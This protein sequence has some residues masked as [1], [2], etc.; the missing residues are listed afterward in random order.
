[1]SVDAR[2]DQKARASEHLDRELAVIQATLD[3]A[4]EG[5]DSLRVL[6]AGCGSA[7]NLR[8][9]PGVHTTGIDISQLQLDRNRDLAERIRGDLQNYPLPEGSFDLVICWDVLEHLE[10]PG[11]ALRNMRRAL[12]PDGVMVLSLPNLMSIKGLV[13]KYTPQAFHIWFYR[14]IYRSSKTGR[15]DEGPFPTFL[16]RAISPKG[17]RRFAHENGLH[18]QH[19]GMLESRWQRLVRQRYGITGRFWKAIRIAIKCV[20]FG[21]IDPERTE[22]IVVLTGPALPS[23]AARK[24][25]QIAVEP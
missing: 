9:P 21:Q 22:L 5:R 7:R 11:A 17:I 2:P 15:D 4:L 16:R 1:M 3:V 10:D 6:D 12:K 24:P 19:F 20:T 8:I 14:R 13:T 25:S 18:V 23:V